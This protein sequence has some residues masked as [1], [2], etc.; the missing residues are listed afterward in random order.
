MVNDD[1]DTVPA[2]LVLRDSAAPRIVPTNYNPD[3]GALVNVR[4]DPETV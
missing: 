1:G 2:L 4:V 3:K